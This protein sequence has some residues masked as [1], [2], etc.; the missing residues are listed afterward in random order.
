MPLLADRCLEPEWMDDPSLPS[1]QHRSALDGLARI[2]RVSR[3]AASIWSVLRKRLKSVPGRPRVLD[4]ACGGGD[5]AVSLQRMAARKGIRLSIDGC[6]ISATA[7]RLA[8][9]RGRRFGLDSGFFRHDALNGS[10]P[11]GYD[12]VISS[13]FLHHLSNDD[14]VDLLRRM[15]AAADVVVVNDLER[16]P[17]GYAAAVL[18]TRLLTRS[19]VVHFDGP[20]SVRGAFT[21]TEARNLAAR[22]GLARARVKSVFPWRWRLDWARP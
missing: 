19:P 9:A 13:L 22:A 8:A 7:V 18:G 4:V 15:G 2:N 20:R 17:F 12:A 21:L 10:L 14:A 5:V 11:G 1:E 6:D 16:G 3:S